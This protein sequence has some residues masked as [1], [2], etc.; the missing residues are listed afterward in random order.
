MINKIINIPLIIETINKK[1]QRVKKFK[2][3]K[4][5]FSKTV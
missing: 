3:N 4:N 2:N 5:K 1:Y